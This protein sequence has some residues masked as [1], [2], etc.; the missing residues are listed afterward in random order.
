MANFKRLICRRFGGWS[1]FISY[2][3]LILIVYLAIQYFLIDTSNGN[4]QIQNSNL[5]IQHQPKPEIRLDPAHVLRYES[6]KFLLL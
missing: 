5:E 3:L 2:I 6:G 4:H 1:N